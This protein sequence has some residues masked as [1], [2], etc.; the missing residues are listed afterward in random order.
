MI[1]EEVQELIRQ[2]EA[3]VVKDMPPEIYEEY[4]AVQKQRQA[5]YTPSVS[6]EMQEWLGEINA[7]L[8]ELRNTN[9]LVQ[10]Y[11]LLV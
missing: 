5:G 9:P 4:L 3:D 8:E 2:A 7:R 6:P 11:L 10:Q 1:A